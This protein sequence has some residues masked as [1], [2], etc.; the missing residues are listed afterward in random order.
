MMSRTMDLTRCYKTWVF[1]ILLDSAYTNISLII[2]GQS[3]VETDT[4]DAD[5]SKNSVIIAVTMTTSIFFSNHACRKQDML[6]SCSFN[7]TQ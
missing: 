4:G 5:A 7:A 6:A 3:P 2:T 1:Y